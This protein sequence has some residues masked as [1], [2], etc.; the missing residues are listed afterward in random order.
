MFGIPVLSSLFPDGL[1]S[2]AA[3]AREARRLGESFSREAANALDQAIVEQAATNHVPRP[4]EVAATFERY[5]AAQQVRLEADAMQ[6]AKRLT[7]PRREMPE[8]TAGR[9]YLE[10]DARNDAYLVPVGVGGA[11][12]RSRSGPRRPSSS[13]RRPRRWYC[14][15]ICRQPDY[16]ETAARDRPRCSEG[17]LGAASI[18]G[19][20][21]TDGPLYNYDRVMAYLR[22]HGEPG[23]APR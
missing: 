13:A 17:P 19:S 6:Q 9:P 20:P 3:I 21:R 22:Q 2:E 12:P 14:L 5:A 8:W 4:E 11:G 18:T 7:I 23:T 15:R 16:L 1:I 10:Y